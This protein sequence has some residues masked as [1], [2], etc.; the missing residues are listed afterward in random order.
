MYIFAVAK[1]LSS[2]SRLLR[3]SGESSRF[4]LAQT[5]R[6]LPFGF[7]ADFRDDRAKLHCVARRDFRHRDPEL[8][9]RQTSD[10]LVQRP[11]IV[12]QLR[13]DFCTAAPNDT[14]A[15]RAY[16]SP[17]PHKRPL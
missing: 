10:V 7:V 4:L 5:E 9:I 2:R 13:F 11:K 16:S 17:P 12:Q 15:P 14:H 1:P 6:S 8:V 3:T